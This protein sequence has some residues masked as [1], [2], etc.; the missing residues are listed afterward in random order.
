MSEPNRFCHFD[1]GG[2]IDWQPSVRLLRLKIAL[3]IAV[4]HLRKR[5][6]F[7]EITSLHISAMEL[8]WDS[9]FEFRKWQR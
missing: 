2:K 3:I 5:C 9:F 4:P 1:K 6:S 8:M 7:R